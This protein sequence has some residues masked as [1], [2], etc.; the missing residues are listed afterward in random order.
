MGRAGHAGSYFQLCSR[1]AAGA[2][3]AA[4]TFSLAACQ[5]EPAGGP[6]TLEVEE[7]SAVKALQTINSAGLK[8]WIRS[9]DRRFR[10]LRMVPEL[11]TR[12]GRPRLLIVRS[13]KQQGL[14]LLVIEASGSPATIST[15]GPLAS[16]RTGARINTDIMRWSSGD[17]SC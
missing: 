14:P 9:G 10:D 5:T 1:L 11:D 6:L 3:L 12:V 4:L 15:Y 17:S 2:A 13:N 8:C 7:S 16:T